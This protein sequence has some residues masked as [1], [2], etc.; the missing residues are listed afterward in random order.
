METTKKTQHG[1]RFL[2][3]LESVKEDLKKDGCEELETKVA[4]VRTV[5][6]N[7]GRR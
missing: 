5:G 2:R 3:W 7:F 1:Q 4:S 6:D